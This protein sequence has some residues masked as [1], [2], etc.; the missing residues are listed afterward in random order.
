MLRVLR[1][2]HIPICKRVSNF[3]L[4]RSTQLFCCM[5]P[6]LTGIAERGLVTPCCRIKQR[7]SPPPLCKT[8]LLYFLMRRAR[9]IRLIICRSRSFDNYRALGESLSLTPTSHPVYVRS[10]SIPIRRILAPT[11]DIGTP[12]ASDRIL[13][14]YQTKQIFETTAAELVAGENF[15]SIIAANQRQ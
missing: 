9:S 1:R 12:Q 6:A 4:V 5:G 7:P 14:Q 2:F 8:R 15:L 11:I 13:K 10:S 3:S